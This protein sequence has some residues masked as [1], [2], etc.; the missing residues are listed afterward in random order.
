MADS[1]D[2]ME[3]MRSLLLCR[4]A[5][6]KEANWNWQQDKLSIEQA[7]QARGEEYNGYPVNPDYFGSYC[8]DGLAMALWSLWRSATFS[9]CILHAVNLLGDADTVGAIAGQLAG[10]LYGYNCIT[11]EEFGQVC[12]DSLRKWDPDAEIG[13]RAAL[14]YHQGADPEENLQAHVESLADLEKSR[15]KRKRDK[16]A[17]RDKKD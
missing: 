13:L 5:T 9:G 16:K 3:R 10:A 15:D 14:L 7:I 8:M 6:P 2:A 11:E 4:P 12:L 17:K 1:E